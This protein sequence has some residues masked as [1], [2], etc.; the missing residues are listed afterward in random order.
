MQIDGHHAATYVAARIA[1]FSDQDAAK[2]AY[3]AQYVDDATNDGTISFLDS[4]YMYQRIASAHKMIDYNNLVAMQNHLA[5]IPFHFLPGNEGLEAGKEPAQG[6]RA[7][8]ICRPDSAVARDMLREAMKDR[9]TPRELHRLGVAMHVYADTFAHQGFVGSVDSANVV[10]DAKSDDAQTDQAIRDATRRELMKAAWGQISAVVQ[11]LLYSLRLAFHEHR[12]PTTFWRNFLSRTPLGHAAADAYPD[13][14]Y[15]KWTYR[16]ASNNVVERDNPPIF[17]EAMHMMTRA[18]RAWRAGDEKMELWRYEGLSPEDEA[19]VNRLFREVKD[20]RGDRRHE[21]WL[22]AIKAGDF[23]FGAATVNYVG[24]GAGSW[25][26][27]ALGTTAVT[28]TGFEQ[29]IY[30]A[31]FLQSDWKHFH[32][33]IQVHR[34]SIVHEVLPR[35]GICAA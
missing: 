19:V 18:M 24:K 11:L 13:Q 25:K 10:V 7:K 23:S 6:L 33:A 2:I 26:H 31:E 34:A 21:R 22:E 12:W 17:V 3:A 16:D 32:D 30:S 9:G 4:P 5:W 28:D 29:Y 35:Y 1:G 14:P 20:P 27:A 15:L 8:L